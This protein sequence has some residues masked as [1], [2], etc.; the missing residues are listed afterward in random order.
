MHSS[1]HLPTIHHQKLI[2]R[3]RSDS[4]VSPPFPF[5]TD[6]QPIKLIPSAKESTLYSGQQRIILICLFYRSSPVL[7]C[8]FSASSHLLASNA[9][10]RGVA[11]RGIQ[12]VPCMLYVPDWFLLRIHPRREETFFGLSRTPRRRKGS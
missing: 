7:P 6:N 4:P 10:C 9:F 11:W 5:C 3:T 12:S 1:M 8:M 2:S